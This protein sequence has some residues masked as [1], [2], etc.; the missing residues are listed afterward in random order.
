MDAAY[1]QALA[2]LRQQYEEAR[3]KL[4]ESLQEKFNEELAAAKQQI[5]ERLTEERAELKQQ[6][7]R[8]I[9]AAH[10]TH[11][12]DLEKQYEKDIE[13]HR[14]ELA[15]IYENDIESHRVKLEK[16]I[17]AE[18]KEHFETDLEHLR[19]QL[20]D[21]YDAQL[22]QKLDEQLAQLQKQHDDEIKKMHTKS[23]ESPHA[24][25]KESFER[26]SPRKSGKTVGQ[27]AR[28]SD[29]ADGE[30]VVTASKTDGSDTELLK[31]KKQL[32]ELQDKYK[33]LQ[34]DF[35]AEQSSHSKLSEEHDSLAKKEQAVNKSLE[36]AN[37]QIKELG[38]V[39]EGTNA[40]VLRQRTIISGNDRQLTQL[41][42]QVG[43]LQSELA[44][45]VK[46]AREANEDLEKLSLAGQEAE[47]NVNGLKRAIEELRQTNDD[48]LSQIS[49][50]EPEPVE[51][52][53]EVVYREE[54]GLQADLQRSTDQNDKLERQ[55]ESQRQ[56]IRQ[57]RAQL[58]V[59][60]N[61]LDTANSCLVAL[62]RDLS[63]ARGSTSGLVAEVRTLREDKAALEKAAALKKAA[64]EKAALEK[65]A[66]E[67]AALEKVA[68]LKKAA[69]KKTGS[70]QEDHLQIPR[71]LI[72]QLT[73]LVVVSSFFFCVFGFLCFLG[74]A[75]EREAQQWLGGNDLPRAAM[76]SPVAWGIGKGGIW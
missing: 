59:V 36:L 19:T 45:A 25:Q 73:V 12:A 23:T 49:T 5:D 17:Y 63:E 56:E 31:V 22:K 61:E 52:R 35:E 42:R 16:T 67:K 74:L 62:T 44:L 72:R 39:L 76:V 53:L 11:R 46:E 70:S 50:K 33:L 43:E 40:T 69:L 64:L 65:A 13:S 2:K 14:S 68:A 15:Q 66:L 41:R 47:A 48:L 9:T 30:V 71:W 26:N 27:D 38:T 20:Q 28:Y 7:D 57:T 32:T 37:Y 34:A 18:T 6:Y 8:E 4:Q 55:N 60:Q 51:E 58:G 21:E 3:S 24:K 10:A 1:E 29:K 75:A 54:A